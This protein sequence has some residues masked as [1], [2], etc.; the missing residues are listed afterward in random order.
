MA[1][2]RRPRTVDVDSELHREIARLSVNDIEQ[3]MPPVVE[4]TGRISQQ[5]R[6]TRLAFRLAIE[7]ARALA[8]FD[9]DRAL[10]L[11]MQM[12]EDW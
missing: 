7:E 12:G 11:R 3:L 4:S 1:L 9:Q 2:A 5:D 10:A 8:A 6:D